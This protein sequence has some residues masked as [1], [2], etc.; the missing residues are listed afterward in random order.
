MF[1]Q[2]LI[3]SDLQNLA[4]AAGSYVS[5]N[6]IDTWKGKSAAAGTPA[7]GGPLTGDFGRGNDVMYIVGIV[8][9]AFTSAGAATLQIQ[10][11]QADDAALTSNVQ[12]LRETRALAAGTQP[13]VFTLGKVLNMQNVP[14]MTK[15][16]L[17]LQYTIGTATT[18]AGKITAG[19]RKGV[20]S[21]DSAL[22]L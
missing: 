10:V 2:N 1:D 8:T 19:L 16:F 22:L 9:Q 11:I 20:F 12:V 18:T 4:Q 15:Q 17:G 5:T 14:S 13:S 6:S 3:F 21:N 7:I